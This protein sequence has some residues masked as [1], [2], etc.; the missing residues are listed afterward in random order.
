M[1]IHSDMVLIMSIRPVFFGKFLNL[2]LAS[3][4]PKFFRLYLSNLQ[5]IYQELN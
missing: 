3:P 2:I 5:I 4:H 1:D